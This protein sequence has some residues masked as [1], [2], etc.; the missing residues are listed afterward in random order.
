MKFFI[1]TVFFLGLGAISTAQSKADAPV[2]KKD[3]PAQ[4]SSGDQAKTTGASADCTWV[5]ANKDG[6]CDIC[7]SKECKGKAAA[8]APKKSGCSP[9]CPVI[10]ECGKTESTVPAKDGK[11][12]D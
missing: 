2:A 8:T 9:S 12:E 1:L 11:K 10:K 7:G 4:I 5:D 3:A 6:L